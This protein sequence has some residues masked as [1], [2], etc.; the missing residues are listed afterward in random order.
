MI[1]AEPTWMSDYEL[2]T[3]GWDFVADAEKFSAIGRLFHAANYDGRVRA[4]RGESVK[5]IPEYVVP[6]VGSDHVG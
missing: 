6:E 5:S 2:I 3:G 4:A 1:M